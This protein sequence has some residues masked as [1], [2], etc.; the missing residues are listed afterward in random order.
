M[1]NQKPR[2]KPIICKALGILAVALGTVGITDTNAI[3]VPTQNSIKLAQVG[4]RSRISPPTPLNLRPRTHTPL[5]NSNYYPPQRT[6][7]GHYH[8]HHH[9]HHHHHRYNTHKRRSNRGTVIIINPPGNFS[10]YGS[11]KSY[12]RT[13]EQ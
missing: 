1:M 3:A 8:H 11:S 10:S 9:H 5:P 6:Y 4:V 13:I 7:G 2:T 12:I